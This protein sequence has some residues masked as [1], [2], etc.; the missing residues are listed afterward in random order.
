M[1]Y[2]TLLTIPIL[3]IVSYSAIDTF[4][5]GAKDN[6][7]VFVDCRKNGVYT[8]LKGVDEVNIISIGRFPKECN[9]KITIRG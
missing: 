2:S 9:Y 8:K 5:G 7:E 1:K 3:I 4:C 6:I